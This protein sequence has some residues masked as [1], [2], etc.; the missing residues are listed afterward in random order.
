MILI[1]NGIKELFDEL[2][3]EFDKIE[4]KEEVKGF[5]EYMKHDYFDWLLKEKE[6]C[7]KTLDKI[8]NDF[9]VYEGVISVLKKR[10]YN[11]GSI[12]IFY[13]TALLFLNSSKTEMS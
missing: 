6:S 1:E 13:K 10:I 3:T 7:S 2:K 4:D 8:L 12:Q 5:L 9:P 11:Y